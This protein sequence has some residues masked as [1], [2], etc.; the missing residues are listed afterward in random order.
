MKFFAEKGNMDLYHPLIL[1]YGKREARYGK[2]PEA[3]FHL[4]AYN[5]VCG[6]AFDIHFDITDGVLQEVRFSGYGCAV[7]RASTAVLVELMEGESLDSLEKLVSGFLEFVENGK[8]GFVPD[9]WVPFRKAGQY[10]GRLKCATLSWSET[11][12][13]LKK[14]Q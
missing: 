9:N 10:P 14:T 4:S 5:P 8:E 7:S 12:D 13:F 2:R 1:E 3:A 11:G 6:D